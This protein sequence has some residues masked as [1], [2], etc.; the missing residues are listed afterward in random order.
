MILRSKQAEKGKY[1]IR[2]INIIQG[3]NTEEKIIRDGQN[4]GYKM[5]D[6]S[7][8]RDTTTEKSVG[9][10]S[11]WMSPHLTGH[12]TTTDKSVG[13]ISAWMSPHLTGHHTTTDK[14]VGDISAWMSPHLTG[15]CTYTPCSCPWSAGGT[16]PPPGSGDWWE[17][18]PGPAA[19]AA[20]AASSVPPS[21]T[22]GS[23]CG[24]CS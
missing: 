9:D 19:A 21:Y 15:H 8:P 5:A 6:I 13:D 20:A 7:Q 14:S 1:H 16:P 17:A 10:I 24:G 3:F 4:Q 12:H 2:W 18:V 11:A 23:R 22:R